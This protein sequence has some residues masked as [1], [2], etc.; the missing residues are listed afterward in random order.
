MSEWMD[1]TIGDLCDTIS[2]TYRRKDQMVVLVNTSDV[3]AGKV[4]NHELVPN[5]KLK[6]QFKKT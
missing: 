1:V 3:L 5:E 4:L 6:G 2:V